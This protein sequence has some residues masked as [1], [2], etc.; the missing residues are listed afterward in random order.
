[1]AI[2]VIS[3][4]KPKNNGDFPVAEAK[5]VSVDEKGTRLSNRLKRTIFAVQT[6]AEM[7]EILTNATEDSVGEYYMYIGATTD[8]YEN[9]IV[10]KIETN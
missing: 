7:D 9:G 5:D 2:E 8:K 10:Y 3:T 4:I 1:M 6:E